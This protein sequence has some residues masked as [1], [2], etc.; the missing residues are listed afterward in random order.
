MDFNE[1]R[2]GVFGITVASDGYY[3]NNLHL[4]PDR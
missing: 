1:E 3:A 2:D 4:A